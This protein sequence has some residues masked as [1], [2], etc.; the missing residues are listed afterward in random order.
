MAKRYVT[1]PGAHGTLFKYKIKYFDPKDPGFGSDIWN[2]FAYNTEHALDKFYDE[3][4]GFEAESISR[5]E[6]RS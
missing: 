1:K 3:D 6:D 2:C 5:V 4:D